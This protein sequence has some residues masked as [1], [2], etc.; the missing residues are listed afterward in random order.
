[1]IHNPTTRAERTRDWLQQGV[2]PVVVIPSVKQGLEIAEGLCAGG[3]TQIEI[4]LRTPE[5]L[6]AMGEIA[7]RFPDL[8][9]SAGTVLT[10]TQ[11]DQTADLGAT[12]FISPGLTEALAEHALKSGYAWVPGVATASE[13]MRALELGFE[14]LKFF[15][16]MAAGGPKALAGITAPLAAA[17]IVPTGG[18]TL[19]NMAQWREVKAV[20]AV[21]GTWLTAG[22]DQVSDIAKVVEQRAALALAAWNGLIQA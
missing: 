5:A 3:I 19:E 18:V 12:L 16:A 9:V 6:Q 21:G 10:P 13:M 2:L 4:T 22:L 15:P 7:K 11:F 1:M 20:Q 14:L 8:R 17:R